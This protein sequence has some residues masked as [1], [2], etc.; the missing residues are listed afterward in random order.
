M[1]EARKTKQINKSLPTNQ[2]KGL[3]IKKTG[4]DHNFEFRPLG[5]P[6]KENEQINP[7]NLLKVYF[8]YYGSIRNFFCD[9]THKMYTA[10]LA[11]NYDACYY[12]FKK[13]QDFLLKS[14]QSVYKSQGI[15]ISDKH[16][17]IIIKQM[18]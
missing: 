16:F 4:L 1:G 9:R 18:T 12:S 17:E 10:R 13:V 15:T 5:M 2:K 11:N 8:N 14:I 7:H 6:I 3:L